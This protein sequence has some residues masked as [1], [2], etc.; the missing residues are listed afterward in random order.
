MDFL[1]SSLGFCAMT[2]HSLEDEGTNLFYAVRK[3]HP[4][5]LSE[6]SN[7]RILELNSGDGFGWFV[8]FWF[9]F[10]LLTSREAL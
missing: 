1:E 6:T 5:P 9:W 8:W 7:N 2:S 10:L 4:F 3:T